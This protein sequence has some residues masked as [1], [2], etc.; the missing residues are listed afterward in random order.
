MVHDH[1][2]RYVLQ[3]NE[4]LFDFVDGNSSPEIENYLAWER[5]TVAPH[6]SQEEFNAIYSKLS[7]YYFSA[8]AWIDSAAKRDLGIGMRMHGV[9]ATIQGGTA[10]VCVVSDGRIEELVDTMG[11][12]HVKPADVESERTLVGLLERVNFDPISF[13]A[14]RENLKSAYLKIA[15]ATG[16]SV[17]L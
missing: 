15:S 12:P 13:D 17:T 7:C 8:P 2:K 3:T 1:E 4:K 5:Q 11:Y 6:L 14:K 9:V 10:G 16:I